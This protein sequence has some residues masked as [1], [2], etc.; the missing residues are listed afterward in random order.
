MLKVLGFVV[1]SFITQNI[2][3]QDLTTIHPKNGQAVSDEIYIEWNEDEGSDDYLI[4]FSTDSNFTN[5]TSFSSTSTKLKLKASDLSNSFYNWRVISRVNGL[6]QDTSPV[7]TFSIFLIKVQDSLNLWLVSDSSNVILVND[8]LVTQWLDNSND[9]NHTLVQNNRGLNPSIKGDVLNGHPAIRF[10][11]TLTNFCRLELTN[12]VSSKDYSIHMVYNHYRDDFRRRILYNYRDWWMGI[13]SREFA[14]SDS[15]FMS[16]KP[17]APNQFVVQNAFSNQ[18][19]L[20]NFVNGI[21]IEK[22]ESIRRLDTTFRLG[23]DEPFSDILEIIMINKSISELE[24]QNID[25]YLM[26]KYAPPVNLGAD[27]TLCSFPDSIQLGIDYALD[28]SWSTG[29][30]TDGIQVDSAGKYY[31]TITDMFERTSVDSIWFI[32]D[33]TD[34]KADFGFVDST[35]CLGDSILLNAG[36]QRFS[37]QW[38]TGD[39]TNLIT[40]KN[41]G[42]YKVTLKNCLGIF[43]SDSIQLNLNNP[44]FNLGPDTTACFN[45]ALLLQPDSNF[46]SVSYQWSTGATSPSIIA[47]TA[48]NYSLEVVDA[49]GCSFIDSIFVT[50]DSGLFNISLGPDTSLCQGNSIGLV[51]QNPNIT[52]YLWSTGNTNPT[53]T[54]DSAGLYTVEFSDGNCIA[55]DSTQISIQGQ[56]PFANYSAS[57]F[58]FQDAVQFNDSSTVQTGD[59]IVSWLWDFQ[60]G[61]TASIANPSHI[62]GQVDSF[63][64]ELT[65]TTDK[66]CTDTTSQLIAIAPKPI[67]NFGIDNVVACSKESIQFT[68]SSSIQFG[69]INNYFWKFNDAQNP[70]DTSLEVEPSYTFDTLG[71]YNISL[72]VQSNKGCSDTVSKLQTINP[73][74]AVGF[75]YDGS[76][77]N[78]STYF[79]NK[80]ILPE[81]II[82]D[83]LWAT[84]GQVSLKE[85]PVFKYLSTGDQTVI[86]RIQTSAGCQNTL[87][88]TIEIF[89]NPNANF[90]TSL[91]CLGDTFQVIDQ[92]TSVDPIVSYNYHFNNQSST[93]KNP[94][95][96]AT[97]L[98]SFNA[99]L[100]VTSANSCEDSIS[101]IVEVNEVPEAAFSIL[102]NNTGIPFPIAL[103]NNSLRA[104]SY[105]WD[106]GNGDSAAVEIPIYTYQDT[107]SYDL[108][109]VAY[110]NAGCKDSLTKKVVAIQSFLDA[111]LER[112]ILEENSNGELGI[113]A[114]ILNIGNNSINSLKLSVD[115]NNRY[116][117]IESFDETIFRGGSTILTFS[118]QFLVDE[119]QKLDFA[120]VKIEEVNGIID[121]VI[122]NNSA[123]EKGFN[124]ELVLS[125]YPNPTS[126]TLILEYVLPQQ[127]ELKI[128]V[129]DQL[130][131][132]VLDEISTKADEGFYQSRLNVINLRPGIYYYNFS[133]N[134]EEINGAFLKR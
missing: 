105:Q 91:A 71:T 107:G 26:D 92:S 13:N 88:D 14:L 4:Q 16:G 124:N 100:K 79:T 93:S 78:D 45:K 130:G 67:A 59:T 5:F 120:C 6:G 29:D 73:T 39:T 36:P 66:N 108:K 53:Q 86:L 77:L 56:A 19:T 15:T 128:N 112:I 68:D 122:V 113:A 125:A 89:E 31:V 42:K 94:T 7:S 43:S 3:S 8:S 132:R 96:I 23:L 76:C 87:R 62:F 98:G 30:T 28:Y 49:F 38:N 47:D 33:T 84:N 109:L 21:E 41:A 55:S 116:Q 17:N 22:K 99:Q 95:F 52:S 61:Q 2:F 104:S 106:F 127:G 18:D 134:G 63:R 44:S 27:R 74:P 131:R 25:N 117:S 1:L 50:I 82:T 12:E 10:E 85:N 126:E 34:F 11:N 20:Y 80:T 83:Y 46:S 97:Q 101:K 119:G 110:S 40:A 115:L 121:D 65:V 111:L 70:G 64:V 37:Y 123:C 90:S 35:I 58:C 48:L 9:S 54:I 69:S 24:R 129:Y 114:Q 133:L 81:G 51:Q 118:N 57:N 72:A 75:N 32:L 60:D 102:N 103:N